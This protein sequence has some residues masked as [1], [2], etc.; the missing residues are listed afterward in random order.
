M[1]LPQNDSHVLMY[2]HVKTGAEVMSLVCRDENKC[3]GAVFRTPPSDSTG[4]PH[5]LE[6]SVLCGSR[7]YP[8]KARGRANERAR[9]H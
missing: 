2:R 9:L 5:I 6:H 1:T 4:I 3:F 7:K 8:I